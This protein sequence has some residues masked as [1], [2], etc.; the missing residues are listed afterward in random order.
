MQLKSQQIKQEQLLLMQ[1]PCSRGNH[2]FIPIQR[3]KLKRSLRG[4]LYGFEELK[5]VV[6][7]FDSIHMSI[8]QSF[9]QPTPQT[10]INLPNWT[11]EKITIFAF[12]F[13]SDPLHKNSSK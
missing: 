5:R 1:I 10:I 7:N 4:I 2:G 9:A 6:I 3:Q 13:S 11:R 12:M 8:M